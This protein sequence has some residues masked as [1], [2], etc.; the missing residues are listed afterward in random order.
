MYKCWNVENGDLRGIYSDWQNKKVPS[1]QRSGE[2]DSIINEATSMCSWHH[3][4]KWQGQMNYILPISDWLRSLLECRRR[5]CRH[6]LILVLPMSQSFGE[7]YV[8]MKSFERLTNAG[9]KIYFCTNSGQV[10]FIQFLFTLV[11][12]KKEEEESYF[13][14]FRF[15]VSDKYRDFPYA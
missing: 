3:L 8:S 15:N 7:N 2:G 14:T 6:V 10:W 1:A 9:D 11:D 13:C 4:S 12:S 5:R